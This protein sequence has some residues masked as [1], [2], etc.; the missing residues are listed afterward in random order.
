EGFAFKDIAVCARSLEPYKNDLVRVFNQN[1][2]PVNINFEEPLL[3]QP[4]ISVCIN[5]LN[6]ARNNFHKDS[7]LS[8][9]NSP[10]L[11]N[12]Q[13]LWGQI[14]KDIGVQTGFNQWLNLLDLAI[15]NGQ[16]E[17]RFLKDFLVKLEDKVA[18]LEEAASFNSLVLRVKDIFNTF[19]DFDILNAQEQKT[20]SRL[21]NILEELA[22]FDKVRPAKK[23]E[24][25]QELNSLLDQEK[26]DFAVNLQNSLTIA[27]I[28]NLRGQAF[29]AVIVLGLNEGILPAKVSEDP[30]FKDIWRSTLQKLGYNIKVSAQRYLEEKMFFYFALSCAEQKGI[31]IY[32]RCDEEGKLQI[33]SVYL[34]WVLKILDKGQRLSIS[35]RPAN[36]LLNWYK[37]APDLLNPKEAAI[38]AA[39]EGNYA[40]ASNLAGTQEEL[41]LS[42]FTLSKENSLGSR[43]L[44]CKEKGVLW[45]HILKK[46]LSPSSLRNLYRCPA[47]YLFD[48]IL[49]RED[50]SILQRDK[51]DARDKGILSHKIL[52]QFYQY[53]IQRN[54]FD[55]ISAAG[56]LDTLQ[57][58]IEKNLVLSDYKKYGLYPLLWFVLCKEIECKIK[59]FVQE[60][61]KR[62]QTQKQRPAYF[63]KNITC[64]FEGLKLHG[65][66]DRIDIS[67]NKD[68]F[69]VVDYKSSK[70]ASA[71]SKLIFEGG[72]FQGPFYFE[73]AKN[74]EELKD[75]EAGE[76]IYASLKDASFKGISYKEYLSFKETFWSL[77]KFL[78]ELIKEGIFIITPN[79]TACQYCSYGDV[80]RKNHAAS[81]RRAVFSK[82]A[83]K[84]REYRSK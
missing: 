54:L 42:A 21:D 32:Q 70:M 48:K 61:I 10:Y 79:K 15:E 24:F 81:H 69:S 59:A 2:I 77:I 38:L 46:G 68:T 49:L 13:V 3:T 55:K 74:I 67:L 7:V 53:L 31:L 1:Y 64:D 34:N 35:R 71:F 62:L 50:I 17:A 37:I 47:K 26:T 11:K 9:I 51:L 84:L 30:V 4:L 57:T 82:Q 60:D 33:P 22:A 6:I 27:D 8:F 83:G 66:I 72:N 52:E 73:M 78:E 28:M 56:S 16:K 65:Q 45:Q 41:F 80:C 63:E 40:L 58:F 76:M 43:D 12:T 36:Q 19:I 14:I 39:L 75:I 23:G 25:L 29:K 44:L 18:L 20:F 5:L